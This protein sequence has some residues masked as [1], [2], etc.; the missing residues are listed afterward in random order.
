M[1]RIVTET[2]VD[3]FK[4]NRLMRDD[5]ILIGFPSGIQ[6]PDSDVDNATLAEWL[7]EGTA[8]IPSRPFLL[9]GMS[10]GRER[11]RKAVKESHENLVRKGVAKALH[12]AVVAVGAVQDFVR[13]DYYKTTIPNALSTIR[14]KSKKRGKKTLVGDRPL[15]DTGFLV[16]SCT[17]VIREG[18]G[19]KV[20]QRSWMKRQLY[21]RHEA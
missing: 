3:T 1:V 17:Y 4:L 6:H 15:I 11:I 20:G 21:E 5:Q 2:K 16:N 10:S 13:G 19:A 14:G 18:T 7:H 8:R 12:V 9:Q